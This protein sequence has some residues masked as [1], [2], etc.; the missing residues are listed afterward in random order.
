MPEIP[1]KWRLL[2]ED[3]LGRVERGDFTGPEANAPRVRRVTASAPF[4]MRPLA[5]R[6]AA[7]EARALDCLNG[8]SGVPNLVSF[9]GRTLVRG[10]IPGLPLQ[11]AEAPEPEFFEKAGRLLDLIHG[12]GVAHNDLA[13]EPNILV[14]ENGEP[15]FVDFQ[16]ASQGRRESSFFRLLVRED[17]RHLLKHKRTYCRES[18]TPEEVA[19]LARPSFPARFW[20]ATGKRV[21]L[22]VTRGILGW[23]DREG[24]GDRGGVGDTP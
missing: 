10:W 17:R 22:G 19:L 6:L 4:W 21:Y 23:A 7:R 16:L 1:R 9:D 11:D 5:R 14:G 3:L 15:A 24:A 13:K 18:L 8:V 20:R 2:K 12:R